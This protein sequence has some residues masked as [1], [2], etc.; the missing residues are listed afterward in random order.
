[1][2]KI[3]V[4]D[5]DLSIR[6]LVKSIFIGEG[7]ELIEAIDGGSAYDVAV[8]EKPDVIL[9]D[10]LT[11]GMDGYEVLERLKDNPDTN[12]IPIIMLT[13]LPRDER[14]RM[15]LG[16]EDYITKPFSREEL[17]HRVRLALG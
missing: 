7:Y 6:A 4:A 8:S 1:M 12:L 11:P 17:E 15:R 10:V 13:A 14:R 16:P 3:L 2:T 5:H 9:L